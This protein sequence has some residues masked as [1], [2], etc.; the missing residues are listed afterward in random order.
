MDLRYDRP[1]DLPSVRRAVDAW[2]A[3]VHC[4]VPK[5]LIRSAIGPYSRRTY[6]AY[7]CP[8]CHAVFEEYYL[9]RIRD[10]HWSVIA[11]PAIGPPQPTSPT[12][13]PL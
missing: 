4:H 10:E 6:A 1:E 3:R 2:A 9:A 12:H 7:V 8:S 13:T 5:A 11:E